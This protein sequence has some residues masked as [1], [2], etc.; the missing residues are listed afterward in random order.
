MYY[1]CSSS[2]KALLAGIFLV[3][4]AVVSFAHF[5]GG[6]PVALPEMRLDIN[7]PPTADL[8]SLAISPD[9]QKVVF[10]ATVRVGPGYGYAH[11]I[12]FRPSP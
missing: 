12:P 6:P 4:L 5:R 2:R 7:T 3:A 8:A 10:V 11:S 9:G 1:I